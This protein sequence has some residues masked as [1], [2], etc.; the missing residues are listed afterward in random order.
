MP[1]N[2]YFT[3]IDNLQGKLLIA[4]P[5]LAASHFEKAII[6]I[7]THNAEGA[8]GLVINHRLPQKHSK[9][10][11]DVL[12]IEASAQIHV[13]SIYLGGPVEMSRGFILHSDD[14]SSKDTQCFQNGI[15][16]SASRSVLKDILHNNGPK[17][18]LLAL[19]YAGWTAG[20]LEDEIQDDSW[21]ITD[22]DKEF[23]FH[24]QSVSKWQKAY[25]LAGIRN[26]LHYSA[27]VGHA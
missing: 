7:C 23:I 5:K 6:Y 22:A 14:Y 1:T 13:P 15:S 16:L 11:L 18:S 17:N 25:E 27:E 12:N 26:V 10:V 4:S 8:M 21:L 19:G 24:P 3:S 20:Q 2:S 9:L